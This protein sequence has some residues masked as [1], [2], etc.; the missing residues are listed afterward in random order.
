LIPQNHGFGT[1]R[2]PLETRYFEAYNRNNVRLVDI[3][4]TPIERIT[5]KGIKT[6]DAEYEF[7]MIIYATGFDAITGAFDRI[8]FKCNY[9]FGVHPID[10]DKC[11][12]VFHKA[13]Y[14]F[15]ICSYFSCISSK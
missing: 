1:R 6:S 14:T 9:N 2:V 11:K 3:N 13:R 8:E 12:F 7:D 15:S 4:E 5:P 10:F